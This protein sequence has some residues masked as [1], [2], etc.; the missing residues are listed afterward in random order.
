MRR[1]FGPA[2]CTKAISSEILE[3]AEPVA[4]EHDGGRR[5][6]W[7]RVHGRQRRLLPGSARRYQRRVD[8]ARAPT[9]H[10]LDRTQCRRVPPSVLPPGE[11]RAVQGIDRALCQFRRR[12]RPSDRLLARRLSVSPVVSKR[13]WPRS[14]R[15]SRCSARTASASIG[16][17]P[18][19]AA[20]L[21]PGLAVDGVLG[22]HVLRRRR[23]RRPER[24]DP[25]FRKAAQ[26]RG[27]EIRR[28]EEVTGI[29]VEGGR[30]TGVETSAASSPLQR[31]QR[32]RRV[33]ASIGQHGRHRRARSSRSAGT[34]SSRS[35]QREAAGTT[36]R[37]GR[38]CRHRG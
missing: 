8:R 6:R 13:A 36:P 26:A 38:A 34:S 35:H 30:V 17:Q 7:R 19:D 3:S 32:R 23:H 37:I 15:T 1:G 28:G 5:D 4:D 10:G 33:G 24:R 2:P 25:G 18:A 16:C 22:S 11:H 12:G 29:R 9:R 14:E 20:D 27:V 31:R 21:C